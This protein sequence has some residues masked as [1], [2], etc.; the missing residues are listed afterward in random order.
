MR[1]FKDGTHL[2]DKETESEWKVFSE[3]ITGPLTVEKLKRIRLYPHSKEPWF[4]LYPQSVY[5]NKNG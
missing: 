5:L 3:A 1:H 4:Q 2:V